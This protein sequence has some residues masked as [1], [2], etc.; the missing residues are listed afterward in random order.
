[1]KVI[2]FFDLAD[3]PYCE[4]RNSSAAKKYVQTS[5]KAK[6]KKKFAEGFL[7]KGRNEPC[8]I[9]EVAEAVAGI[10]GVSVAEL[11]EVAYENSCKV[12]KKREV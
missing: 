5:F 8:K 2:I 6:D 11:A 12:F 10:K 4:I 9:L 7:V 3:A 1:M